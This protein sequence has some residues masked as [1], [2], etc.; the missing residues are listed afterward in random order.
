MDRL[1]EHEYSPAGEILQ[2]AEIRNINLPN[3]FFLVLF[4]WLI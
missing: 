4:E 1:K 2:I 3:S